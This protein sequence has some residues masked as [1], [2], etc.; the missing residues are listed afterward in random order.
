MLV[1]RVSAHIDPL[2]PIGRPVPAPAAVVVAG[3][4]KGRAEDGETTEV[5]VMEEGMAADEGRAGAGEARTDR[6]VREAGA[7]EAWPA[8]TG[9]GKTR[10][11]HAADMHAA[12]TASVH[13]ATE[14]TAVHPAAEA[15]TT[16]AAAPTSTTSGEHGRSDRQCRSHG[17]RDDAGEKPVVHLNIL[18]VAATVSPLEDQMRKM[19][20]HLQLTNAP[21][22]DAEVREVLLSRS[23]APFL[24]GEG[25]VRGCFREYDLSWRHRLVIVRRVGWTSISAA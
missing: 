20:P 2:P 16:M 5:P 24:R 8:K 17:R 15:A 22:S 1:P 14:A 9:A 6:R 19:R 18:L 25:G 11:A 23:L 13:S 3:I 12:E 10:A 4:D 7:A 21:D